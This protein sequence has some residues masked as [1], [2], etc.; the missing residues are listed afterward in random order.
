MT[1]SNPSAPLDMDDQVVDQVLGQPVTRRELCAAFDRVA[2]KANWKMP[3]DAIVEIATHAELA[4]IR[5][6]V[7]FFTGSV[8]TFKPVAIIRT[9]DGSVC[10]YRV[11]ADGYYRAVGA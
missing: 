8:P 7:I 9:L 1:T 4:T 3:V 11:V 6:A 2:D 5:Q 10:R